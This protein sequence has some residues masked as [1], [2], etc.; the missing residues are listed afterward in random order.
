MDFSRAGFVDA[1]QSTFNQVGRDQTIYN[2][3]QYHISIS[4]VGS[5]QRPYRFA[6]DVGANSLSRPRSGPDILSQ[7]NHLVTHRATP[8]VDTTT[9]LIEQIIPL[10]IDHSYVSRNCWDLAIELESLH[11]TLTLTKLAIHKYEDTPLSQNLANIIAPEVKQCSAALQKL[12][13]SLDGTWLNFSITSIGALWRRIWCGDQD[14]V[15]LASS[16]KMLSV[17]RQS[18][19]VLLVTLHSYVSL[20]PILSRL[21]NLFRNQ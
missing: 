16:R 7:G 11:Q 13:D 18:L 14:E 12:W 4:P 3:I 8:D 20:F 6:V 1:R 5:Q 2:R 10:L 21:L 9:G 17:S 19:Q 15:G